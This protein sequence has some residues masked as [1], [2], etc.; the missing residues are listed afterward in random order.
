[1]SC[2]GCRSHVEKVLSSVT[3]VIK[4]DVN[5]KEKEAVIEMKDHISLKTF[6]ETLSKSGG[7]YSIHELNQKP[8]QPQSKSK[9]LPKGS[10]GSWYCPMHCEG[11]KTYNE[12]GDCPVCGMDYVKNEEG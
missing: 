7:T 9:P 6:Q 12:S 3:G 2:N 11:D 4:A 1:M 8:S 5:L 10:S